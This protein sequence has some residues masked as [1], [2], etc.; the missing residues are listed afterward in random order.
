[1]KDLQLILQASTALC[2]IVSFVLV[3]VQDWRSARETTL[4]RPV[5]AGIAG[6]SIPTGLVL[7]YG[8]FDATV[9][10][11]LVTL[12]VYLALAGLVLI[13]VAIKTIAG[14]IVNLPRGGSKASDQQAI[15][16]YASQ[17]ATTTLVRPQPPHR[18]TGKSAHRRR[19]DGCR[20][21]SQPSEARTNENQDAEDGDSRRD[22]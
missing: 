21:R 7:I 19:V 18:F 22:E 10:Q 9:I 14:Q 17:Q 13:F 5:L 4:D 2:G 15:D 20:P 16:S 11:E 6:T 8:A 1:M 12:R 3:W